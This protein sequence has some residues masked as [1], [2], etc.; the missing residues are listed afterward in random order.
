MLR[1]AH[2]CSAQSHEYLQ[3]SPR[4]GTRVG[5]FEHSSFATAEGWK[6]DPSFLRFSTLTQFFVISH[7]ESWPGLR[8]LWVRVSQSACVKLRTG[9]GRQA[10]AILTAVTCS[11]SSGL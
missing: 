8:G 2:T 4:N 3:G 11:V 1:K 6:F 10:S 5:L 7:P 9:S